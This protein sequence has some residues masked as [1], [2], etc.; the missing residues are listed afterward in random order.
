[1]PR[2]P[3]RK[4]PADLDLSRHLLRLDDLT[5]PL[6]PA[7]LFPESLPVE[8]EVGSG[9]G[10]FLAAA[11]AAQPTRN[12]LGIEVSGGYAR[13]AAGKLAAASCP[14]GRVIHGDAMQ[15]VSSLLPNRCLIGVHVYF[16]DPWWKARHRK[17][18]ILNPVF[19]AHAARL[20]PPDGQLHIWTDVAEYFQEAVAATGATGRFGPPAEE[21]PGG[22]NSDFR[23]HFERRTRL[24]GAPVWRAVFQR[25]EQ[26][27][28]VARLTTPA[29]SPDVPA[30]E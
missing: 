10:M 21:L 9:K 3:P 16:P 2:R 1:M 14:N 13:L 29:V 27:A 19:L 11:T 24:A 12:Y 25:N 5:A 28:A 7:S 4:P 18:R 30:A 22:P 17:R 23:T 15:L 8:L 20:L 6:E 26:P